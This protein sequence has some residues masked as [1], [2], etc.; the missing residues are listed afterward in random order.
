M[1]K[2]KNKHKYRNN[3]RKSYITVYDEDSVQIYKNYSNWPKF[4]D[5]QRMNYKFIASGNFLKTFE[6]LRLRMTA[7]ANSE[8]RCECCGASAKD[9]VQLNVDHVMP[10]KKFPHLALE[11]SNLQILCHDCNYGKGND[12]MI[13]WKS[14]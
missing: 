12:F 1:K 3:K 13:H 11:L 6:W 5:G 14:I 4:I 2:S 7:L 8:G 10:R 9:G